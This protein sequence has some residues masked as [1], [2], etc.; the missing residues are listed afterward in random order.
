MLR[1]TEWLRGSDGSN[2][3]C[4]MSNPETGHLI[5][6]ELTKSV[7][8]AFYDVYGE[9]QYGFLEQ[10][11]IESLAR[12][13]RKRG[14]EVRREV[15][16]DIFFQ[17]EVVGVQRLDLLVDRKLIVEVKSTA[18]LT[19]SSHR[20]LTSYLRGSGLEVGLLLHFGPEAKFHRTICTVRP[21]ANRPSWLGSV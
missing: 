16:V 19:P 4:G 13:L 10:I 2:G 12:L 20:Q 6:G 21:P 17:G 5:H 1:G 11:Y 7:I 18:K 8:G 14:H 15:G 9:L 3:S